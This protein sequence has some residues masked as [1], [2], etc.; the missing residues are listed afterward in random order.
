MQTSKDA[1]EWREW[2]DSV[3]LL[4]QN[5]PK[6][7][8]APWF[9]WPV[10]AVGVLA[11][12]SAAVVFQ[13]MPEVHPITLAAWR[14]QLT[15]LFLTP[16][17]VIEWR[18]MSSEKRLN[19]GRSW[20]ILL[21]SGLCLF[22]H[23]GTFV[24]GLQHTS[25]PHSLLFLSSTP[26]VLS[27]GAICLRKPISNGELLGTLFGI[28]G[29]II[30]VLSSSA[31]GTDRA[32]ISGDIAS[33]VA[34]VA[35][36][37]YLSC[38]SK[39]REWMPLFVYALPVT[40]VAALLLSL[41]AMLGE[42]TELFQSGSIGMFGWAASGYW[43]K[44][45]YLAACPGLLGHTAFNVLL[46]WMSPLVIAL[47]C[48]MEPVVGSL[49]GWAVGVSELPSRATWGGGFT[50]LL[51]LLTVVISSHNRQRRAQAKHDASLALSQIFAEDELEAQQRSLANP[52]ASSRPGVELTSRQPWPRDLVR[53]PSV[54]GEAPHTWASI[55]VQNVSPGSSS[56]PVA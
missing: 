47:A 39:L 32:S 49:I 9:A 3:L 16:G 5:K 35:I 19:T 15:T 54:E 40:G 11:V 4:E 8:T 24:W 14:L 27:V 42:H 41:S 52:A 2:E 20:W 7:R 50:L 51:A 6:P 55:D 37:G 12:S 25:L 56:R 38:G 31:S 18:K 44:V 10:L 13:S 53:T 48:M 28:V 22:V 23:F 29:S 30:L 33:F 45:V 21:A 34:A 1:E 36:A 17:A 43:W 46:K 26:M